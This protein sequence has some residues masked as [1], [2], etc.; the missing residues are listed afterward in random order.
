MGVANDLREA[1]V[2]VVKLLADFCEALVFVVKLLADFCER[3]EEEV[4]KELADILLLLDF[5]DLTSWLGFEEESFTA[6]MFAITDFTGCFD[7]VEVETRPVL[8]VE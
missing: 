3:R 4:P 8:V 2:F 1:L 5:C 7:A 6:P